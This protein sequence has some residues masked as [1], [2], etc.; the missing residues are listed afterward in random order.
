MCAN[1][2]ILTFD[3]DEKL[4]EQSF[5][6]LMTGNSEAYVNLDNAEYLGGLLEKV[7]FQGWAYCE[8]EYDNSEKQVLLIFKDHQSDRCYVVSTKAQLRSDVY[9]AFKKTKKIYNGMNGVE[10]QFSCITMNNGVYDYYVGVIENEYNYGIC[11]MH[12][13]YS[14]SK[15]GLVLIE[16]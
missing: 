3:R 2:I 16:K 1:Q 5:S 10:C 14:K 12:Q 6:E 8:T 9:G 7:Y 11:D 13:Q 4:V 15:D